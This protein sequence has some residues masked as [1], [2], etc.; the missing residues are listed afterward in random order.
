L[1]KNLRITLQIQLFLFTGIEQ[2]L[3]AEEVELD[4][5]EMEDRRRE[6]S[7][8]QQRG[9]ASAENLI[10]SSREWAAVSSNQVLTLQQQLTEV[11]RQQEEMRRKAAGLRHRLQEAGDRL[12]DGTTAHMAAH[13]EMSKCL[14]LTLFSIIC[15]S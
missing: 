14:Y 9:R 7:L 10:S 2:Q 3:L 4:P 6:L 8:M 13:E 11:L 1:Y 15:S 5:D 12:S